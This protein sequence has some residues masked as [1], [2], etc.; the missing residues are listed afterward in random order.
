VMSLADLKQPPIAHRVRY[1]R[2]TRTVP[3]E[4]LFARYRPDE[5]EALLGG[6]GF[7]V[8]ERRTGVAPNH[9]WLTFLATRGA[10]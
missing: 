6:A 4:R 7:E 1:I 10:G 5:A 9:R 3:G 8:V 2:K